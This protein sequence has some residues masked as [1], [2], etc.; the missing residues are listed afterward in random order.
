[1][2]RLIPQTLVVFAAAAGAC[3]WGDVVELRSGARLTGTTPETKSRSTITVEL[4]GGGRVT[5]DR[6]HVVRVVPESATEA[7]YRRRAPTAPDTVDAQWALARWCQ[8][9][10]MREAFRRHLERVVELDPTHA[11][12]RQ[13]LGYQHHEGRWLTRAELMAAR[14]MVRHGGE[15]RTRQEVALLERSEQAKER[16]ADWKNT[17]ARWR[18]DLDDRDPRE[19]AAAAANYQALKDPAAGPALASQLLEER[20]PTAKSLLIR[21]AA[22]IHHGSTVRGLTALALDDNNEEIRFACL[23]ELVRAGT[24]GLSEPF[25][26][27]LRSKDN[28]RINRAAAA[29][30]ELGDTGAVDSLVNALVTTHKFKVGE[31]TG[32]GQRFDITS[33]GGGFRFGGGGTKIIKRNLKNQRVLSALVKLTGVNYGYDEA[34]WRAWL[35]DRDKTAAIDLRRDG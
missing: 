22:Q 28:E 34:R 23:E 33:G 24:P 5:L 7:E 27:A 9:R 2:S 11:E 4:E 21:T 8:E 16:N 10:G 3:A 29:I 14:G 32:G 13:L 31:D 17:L 18:R 30:Q 6:D 19:A 25:V 1:M 35:E 26:R 20:D 15:Y 12:A